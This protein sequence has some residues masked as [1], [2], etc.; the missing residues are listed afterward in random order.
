MAPRASSLLVLAPLLALLAPAACAQVN[1]PGSGHNEG[2]GLPG[3]VTSTTSEAITSDD[4]ISRAQQWVNAKLLYCQ[5]A[6]GAPDYD[7]SCPSTCTRQSNSQWDPYRSD[8]SGFISWAWGLAAP[9]LVTSEFAPFATSASTTIQAADL[10]PGDACNKNAG[11][12]IVLFEKWV[13]PGKTALFMEEPGCSA[14]PDYAH[15][16]QSDVTLNGVNIDIA[17][18]GETFTAIRYTQMTESPADAG[19]PGNDAGTT[20][21]AA[22]TD[23]KAGGQ[24]AGTSGKDAGA[25]GSSSG[26]ASGSSSGAGTSSGG[27]GSTSSSGGGSSSGGAATG[28]SGGN[29]AS[30]G[31]DVSLDHNAGGMGCDVS[32]VPS[33][34]GEAGVGLLVVGLALVRRRRLSRAEA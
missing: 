5:S 4:A 19:A 1:G 13:T 2:E 27:T 26:S 21:D 33:R 17:Y 23:A 29:A 15:E 22:G 12:H 8:C 3:E 25:S 14:S 11:G 20:S 34:G 16:F 9:G 18:E 31:N 6:N 10:Q 28:S 24:D 7:T 32:G 30:S